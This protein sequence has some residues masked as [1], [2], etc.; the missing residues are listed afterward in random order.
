MESVIINLLASAIGALVIAIIIIVTI[1]KDKLQ[2]AQKR[3]EELQR[4]YNIACNNYDVL[5]DYCDELLNK[6]KK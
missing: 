2:K 4:R 1:Y 5:F 3:C 6:C